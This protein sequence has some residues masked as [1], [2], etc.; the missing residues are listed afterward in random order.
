MVLT[1]V[2]T[3][4]EHRWDADMDGVVELY[5]SATKIIGG[6]G[7]YP[8]G[9]QAERVGVVQPREEKALGRPYSGLPV[10]QGGYRKDEEG[11]LIRGCRGRTNGTGFKLAEGRFRLDVRKKFFTVRVVR[12]WNWLPRAVVSTPSLEGF[13][14]RLDGALSNL[15]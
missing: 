9:G 2:D 12:H 7:A 14:T 8:L 5:L 4:E 13:K 11:L 10:L 15:D 3:A 6:A 1:E